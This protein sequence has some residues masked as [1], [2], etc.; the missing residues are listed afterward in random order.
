MIIDGDGHFFETEEIFEKYMEPSLRN[1]RPRL[2]SDDQGYNY[3]VVAGQTP[4]RRPSIK[5]AG[6]PSLLNADII[7]LQE[8]A[9][10]A[11]LELVFP[12]ATWSIVIDDDSGDLQDLAIVVRKPLKV[13]APA[14]LDAD[15]VNFL[16]PGNANENH[17]PNRRDI[18]VA[19][20]EVQQ[21]SPSLF[22]VVDHAKSRLGGR[23]TTDP[24]REGAA[25]DLVRALEMDF[26]D[27][28]FIL[29]GDFN[30][31]PD[32]RSL[33]ILET[34]NP[35]APG[36]P[37]EIDGPFLTN[38]SEALVVA[39]RVS[40]GRQSHDIAGDHINTVDPGSRKRNNDARGTD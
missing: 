4:Y 37:E 19:E 7:G 22:V 8:I 10:R 40:W 1:Y 35:D 2:L 17:F 5:G 20:I 15:D 33:N 23:A 9:D 14:D 36:G 16:F 18:L 39:D 12:P 28:G 3:W 32:D 21:G 38:L 27:R 25:R 6:A 31:N 11:A 30:D 26:D 29:M 34:G 24:R 13:I